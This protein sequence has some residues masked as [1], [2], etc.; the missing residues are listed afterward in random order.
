MKALMS[1]DVEDWFQVENLNSVIKKSDWSLKEYRVEKNVETILEVLSKNNT[2]ATF[3]VLGW[4]A[5][6][7]PELI[8]KISDNGHE[9]ASHGYGHDLIYNLDKNEFKNDVIKS[10][11]I[12]EDITG[13]QVYGYRAPSFSITDWAV[14][15]LIDTGFLYDTS[16]FQSFTHDRYGKLTGFEIEDK[17]IF[18]LKKGFYQVKLSCLSL[19]NKNIPWA[20]GGYFRMI[21]YFLFKRGV[22]NILI[23]QNIFCFYIH[24]WE[25]DPEQ[26]RVKNIK[27]QYK[28][29]HYNNLKSTKNKFEK[30]VSDFNFSRIIDA[31][32]T[33]I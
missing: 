20:G 32:I 8:K 3:F 12:L 24:P 14:D 30:L 27:L 1:V 33:K 21:P 4:I 2:K 19:L 17:P 31:L 28:F 5:E 7:F 9:I 6:K 10:K 13:K 18:E 11:S 16:L 29:R 15:I 25:F 22:K 26:P 23:K